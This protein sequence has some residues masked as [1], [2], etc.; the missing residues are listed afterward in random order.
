MPSH[1]SSNTQSL[2]AVEGVRLAG[3]REHRSER[4]GALRRA[5]RGLGLGAGSPAGAIEVD[6][7]VVRLVTPVRPPVWISA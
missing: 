3:G 4:L 5:S 2:V 6:E 7:P 1:L